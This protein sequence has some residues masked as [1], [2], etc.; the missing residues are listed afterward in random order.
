MLTLGIVAAFIVGIVEWQTGG[1]TDQ[2]RMIYRSAF[3]IGIIGAAIKIS[4]W[5]LDAK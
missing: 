4:I 2:S 1:G 5:I 3:G